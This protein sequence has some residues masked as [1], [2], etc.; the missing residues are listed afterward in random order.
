M[1]MGRG[2]YDILVR[3]GFTRARAFKLDF[4]IMLRCQTDGLTQERQLQNGSICTSY[5]DDLGLT[6]M[7]TFVCSK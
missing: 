6:N 3:R 5:L 1:S 2:V 4:T 7:N